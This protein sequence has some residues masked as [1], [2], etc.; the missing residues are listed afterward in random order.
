MTTPV[1]GD[2]LRPAGEHIS[3]AVFGADD[4]RDDAERA[5][6]RELGRASAT[7]ARYFA[8]LI[9][10]EE[11]GP[12]RSTLTVER[13]ALLEARA[14]MR[15]AASNLGAAATLAQ[16]AS[17]NEEH[18]V[19]QHLRMAAD[20]LAAGRDMLETHFTTGPFGA[21]AGNSYWAPVITSAPV[22]TALLAELA[23]YARGLAPWAAKLSVTGPSDS[24]VPVS[25]RMA[26]HAASRWLWVAGKM[27]ETAQ[28]H[29]PPHADGRALLAAI[30]ANVPPPYRPLADAE[31]VPV[32]CEG[33]TITAGRLRHAAFT[34]S[35]HA[36]WSPAATSASWRRDAL[37]SAI[38]GHSSESI[39]RTLAAHS[40]DLGIPGTM[41]AQVR[42]AAGALLKA[43]PAW[44]GATAHW[45]TV[46]TGAHRG[47]GT[48]P[49]AAEIG[50]LVLR[51]ERL[52]A[53]GSPTPQG[54]ASSRPRPGMTNFQPSDVVDVIGTIHQAIDA[55]TRIAIEDREAIR[56]AAADRR[57]FVPTRLVNADIPYPYTPAPRPRVDALLSAY[58]TAI[59]V[60]TRAVA[61]LDDIAV[62]IGS[63]STVLA[64]LHHAPPATRHETQR[65]PSPETQVPLPGARPAD[66]WV[67]RMLHSLD[68]GD[69]ALLTRAAII[70]E[71]IRDLIAD[72]ATEK[73]APVRAAE[74]R[75][76]PSRAV[77]RAVRVAGQDTPSA[78]NTGQTADLLDEAHVQTASSRAHSHRRSCSQAP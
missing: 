2:F 33:I 74:P 7:L 21:R 49:V 32:L 20:H 42:Q 35:E 26:L 50:D 62:A 73:H 76:N 47:T 27:T 11:S 37:A 34:F 44:R 77:G 43:W 52:A 18:P 9:P 78:R 23:A 51:V 38:T 12:A 65:W 55:I 58:D 5:A 17:S 71:A 56:T 68:I 70:D 28:R 10:P 67:Q 59:D 24:G 4:L 22:T 13:R 64:S 3:A 30:P 41:R 25:A 69:P 31:T 39:L 1:F 16:D 6:I 15:R 57:L 63:P 72:A 60:S 45:D 54:H 61:I 46:T 8:D 14:A 48:T 75:T 66:T 53:L 40:R 19:V 36:R 29:Q